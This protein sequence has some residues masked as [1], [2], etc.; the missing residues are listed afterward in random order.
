MRR[1]GDESACLLPP[2]NTEYGLICDCRAIKLNLANEGREA[3]QKEEEVATKKRKA[4]DDKAW[5]GR[6]FSYPVAACGSLNAIRA[7]LR[8][9]RLV[10]ELCQHPEKEEEIS[11]ARA[12]GMNSLLLLVDF[13]TSTCRI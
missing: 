7:P 8:E 5:E 2:I 4:E 12:A 9:G 13:C 6:C 11:Q 3:R 1:F 10:A